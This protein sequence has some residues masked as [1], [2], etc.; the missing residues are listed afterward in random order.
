VGTTNPTVAIW[1]L[2]LVSLPCQFGFVV[3]IRLHLYSSLPS[4]LMDDAGPHPWSELEPSVTTMEGHSH[5]QPD[6]G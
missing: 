1:G 6:F 2:D 5:L 4:C 3:I